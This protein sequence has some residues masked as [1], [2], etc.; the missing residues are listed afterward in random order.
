MNRRHAAAICV[1]ITVAVV[2]TLSLLGWFAA[3]FCFGDWVPPSVLE[4]LPGA[5]KAHVR[6]LLGEP[7]TIHLGAEIERW[8]YRPILRTAEFRVD[9]TLQGCVD[10]WSYDRCP[11]HCVLI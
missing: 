7:T 5:T 4:R 9:F 10:D 1:G 11:F 2:P 8:E 3:E 6:E